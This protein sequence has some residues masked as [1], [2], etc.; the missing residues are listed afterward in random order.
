M[1]YLAGLL[2]RERLWGLSFPLSEDLWCSFWPENRYPPIKYL[3]S[4]SCVCECV[5][6]CVLWP[7][8][9]SWDSNLEINSWVGVPVIFMISLSWS[10]SENGGGGRGE[11]SQ[12]DFCRVCLTK[13]VWQI[14]Q[15][16]EK[17]RMGSDPQRG[18][19]SIVPLSRWEVNGAFS[20][21]DNRLCLRR[22]NASCFC[23]TIW[24]HN[25]DV[26]TTITQ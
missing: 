13:A 15:R 21:W 16:L 2:W 18:A 1:T 9:T 12:G 6:V 11:G 17:Q 4:H 20:K 23:S 7:Q 14:Y 22:T 8:L 24:N 5:C 26:G 3:C 10:R 19:L 25:T